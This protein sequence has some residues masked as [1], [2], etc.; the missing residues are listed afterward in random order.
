[1][2]VTVYAATVFGYPHMTRVLPVS[3]NLEIVS[4]DAA[5]TRDHYRVVHVRVSNTMGMP[6]RTI[7]EGPYNTRS[8]AQARV[9]KWVKHELR[10]FAC[11]C[12][13]RRVGPRGPSRITRLE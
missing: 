4:G 12:A 2:T 8:E 13:G 10:T 11:F 9:D 6:R 3:R 7:F 5:T 1:M